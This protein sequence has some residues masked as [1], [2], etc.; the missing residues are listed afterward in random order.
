MGKNRFCKGKTPEACGGKRAHL[1]SRKTYRPK[2]EKKKAGEISGHRKKNKES[3]SLG[4]KTEPSPAA[5][6]GRKSKKRV[7]VL[8]LREKGRPCKRGTSKKKNFFCFKVT[9]PGKEGYRRV[10][11]CFARVGNLGHKAQKVQ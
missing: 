3:K 10:C 4:V 2:K 8:G 1:V 7:V 9:R 5:R 6:L 11:P